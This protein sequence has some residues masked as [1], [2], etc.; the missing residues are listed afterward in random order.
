MPFLED[1]TF[2]PIY[3]M[4]EDLSLICYDRTLHQPIIAV[5]LSDVAPFTFIRFF[6]HS[7]EFQKYILSN[8]DKYLTIFLSSIHMEQF[9][10]LFDNIHIDKINIFCMFE[11]EF[12]GIKTYC[13]RFIPKVGKV[14]MYQ[15]LEYELLL[16]GVEFCNRFADYNEERNPSLV[17]TYLN[18]G[19]QLSVLLQQYYDRK[20]ENRSNPVGQQPDDQR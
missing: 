5:E 10:S 16:F 2:S 4:G 7:V 13:R 6:E 15:K 3:T 8:Q 12:Q 18:H 11:N 1:F 9:K 19:K 17:D 20:M 14:F